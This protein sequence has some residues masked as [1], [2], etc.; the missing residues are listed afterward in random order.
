MSGGAAKYAWVQDDA[1]RLMERVRARDT[2]AFEAL[3]DA[4]RRLVYGIALR[5]VSD[6]GIAEDVVQGVFL[7]VWRSP[8]TFR[9]GNFVAWIT[10]IT[11]NQAIDV[12]R[13]RA[14]RPESEFPEAL[15]VEDAL[16][17]TALRDLNA[18]SIRRAIDQLPPEQRAPI[19]LGFF[20]GITHEEIARRS[21]VPLGTVKTRIRS[22]LRKL[23]VSLE[24]LVQA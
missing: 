7:K 3:Y 18:E 21:G 24:G 8:T 16:E 6:P 5:M 15:P 23:R 14:A 17:D 19:E 12:L 20:G 2:G 9:D 10:R 4:Y 11:R 22:G 13:S 1:S